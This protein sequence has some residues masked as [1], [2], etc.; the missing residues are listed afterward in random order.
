MNMKIYRLQA[1]AVLSM[2]A[3]SAQPAAAASQDECSIWLC[4]PGG[5]PA[6]CEKAK[7]AMLKRIKKGKSPLPEFSS[8]AVKDETTGTNP[9]DFSF[10]FDRVIRI[11]EHK[12][13]VKWWW[14]EREKT[15]LAYITVPAHDRRGYSCYI[16]RGKDNEPERIEGCIGSFYRIKVFEKGKQ[17]G[18]TYYFN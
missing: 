1:L 18:E 5:F 4:A 15:C 2:M 6:G 12:Q 14:G 13:C 9:E 8:C 11:R 10:S 16:D 7:T 17:L 3:F